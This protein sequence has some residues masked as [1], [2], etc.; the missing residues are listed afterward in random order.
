MKTKHMLLSPR[1][2]NIDV[3]VSIMKDNVAIN[4]TQFYTYLDYTLDQHLSIGTFFKE[5]IQRVNFK[6]Y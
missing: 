6:L 4:N 3:D 1:N 2:K 5:T